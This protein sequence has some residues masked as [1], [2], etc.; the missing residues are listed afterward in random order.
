MFSNVSFRGW[1]FY[2]GLQKYYDGQG[3]TIP[4]EFVQVSVQYDSF[5][6]LL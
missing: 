4:E 1:G 2:Y 5:L 6:K 3:H